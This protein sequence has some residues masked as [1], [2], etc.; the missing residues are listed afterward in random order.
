MVVKQAKGTLAGKEKKNDS[1]D[2]GR[3][4]MYAE[5][6]SA[7]DWESTTSVPLLAQQAGESV[8]PAAAQD[9]TGR[10]HFERRPG[11]RLAKLCYHSPYLQPSH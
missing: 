5:R 10:G 11:E 1:S 8:G 7:Y 2:M 9:F 4:G 3:C 6:H